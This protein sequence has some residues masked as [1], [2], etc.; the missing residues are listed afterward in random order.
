MK[1]IK[2][3]YLTIF[4]DFF[5]WLVTYLAIFL[6]LMAIWLFNKDKMFSIEGT[7]ILSRVSILFLAIG[8]YLLYRETRKKITTVSLVCISFYLFQMGQYFVYAIEPNNEKLFFKSSYYCAFFGNDF[9]L[10]N[11]CVIVTLVGFAFFNLGQLCYIKL[12]SRKN[13][14]IKIHYK[15]SETFSTILMLI[16]IVSTIISIHYVI[17]DIQISFSSTYTEFI[18]S[19]SF[20]GV[21]TFYIFIAPSILGIYVFSDKKIYKLIA[22]FIGIIYFSLRFMI[23]GRTLSV[24]F[25]VTLLLYYFIEVK[26]KKIKLS[27]IIIIITIIY[28]AASFLVCMHNIRIL[29]DKNIMTIIANFI[30]IVFSGTAIKSIIIEFGYNAS[31]LPWSIVNLSSCFFGKTY[32]ASLSGLIPSSL[33]IFHWFSEYRMYASLDAKL[34]ASLNMGYGPGMSMIAEAFL[35]C[36][37]LFFLPMF[38]FGLMFTKLSSFDL[39]QKKNSFLYYLQLASFSTILIMP[40]RPFFYLVTTELYIG[41][42]IYIIYTIFRRKHI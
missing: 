26:K 7:L 23:G 15:K 41:I 6:L 36:K 27:T 32:L 20:G 9:F 25:F 37:C 19:S 3:N 29:S 39:N 17:R 42:L 31:S 24:G 21:S 28:F 35:N 11:I 33:D 2:I 12:S 10:L 18:Q 40:R 13:S 4:G 38:L 30:N 14:S 16:L 34:G 1:K 22:T 5:C 8:L